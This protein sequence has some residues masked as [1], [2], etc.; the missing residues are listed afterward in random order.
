[1]LRRNLPLNPKN[2]PNPPHT[3]RRTSSRSPKPAPHAALHLF[4]KPKTRPTR[5]A[6]PIQEVQ[7]P[8]HTQR[9]THSRSPKPA[10]HTTPHLFKIPKP[11]RRA[12]LHL[13]TTSPP[14]HTPKKLRQLTTKPFPK[15]IRRRRTMQRALQ[16]LRF[17]QIRKQLPSTRQHHLTRKTQIILRRHHK[18]RR[19][20]PLQLLHTRRPRHLHTQIIRLKR[21][22]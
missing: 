17:L 9:C 16:Q 11:T 22:R 3:Q 19:I 10:P 20:K 14:P 4:K 8:P 1:M 15:R 6:A 13:F 2:L 5:S 12:A 18:H 21:H 7:N